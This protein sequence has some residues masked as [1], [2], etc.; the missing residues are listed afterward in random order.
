PR[1]NG[2]MRRGKKKLPGPAL[3]LASLVK[4][5]IFLIRDRPPQAIP[6]AQESPVTLPSDPASAAPKT[7]QAPVTPR[8]TPAA[9]APATAPATA[10]PVSSYPPTNKVIEAMV[11]VDPKVSDL[12]FSPLRPPQVELNGQLIPVPGLPPLTVVDTTR[13]ATDLIQG[14]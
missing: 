14:N 12:I 9:A 13:I 2:K 8:R 11:R 4:R 1:V 7:R 6:T 5:G 10:A 3:S